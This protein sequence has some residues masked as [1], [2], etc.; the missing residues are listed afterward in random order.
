MGMTAFSSK[1]ILSHSTWY[2]F[3]RSGQ[4][5]PA[6]QPKA[7]HYIA[8]FLRYDVDRA[9]GG[10]FGST[11]GL[12]RSKHA[13]RVFTERRISLAEKRRHVR[14]VKV[15]NPTRVE[16]LLGAHTLIQTFGV[17]ASANGTVIDKIEA[18]P[19]MLAATFMDPPWASSSVVQRLSLSVTAN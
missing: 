4:D 8:D 11:V 12:E 6:S 10:I 14:T 2:K 3:P 13:L 15:D 5:E 19:K 16:E 17:W 18:D 1:W 9:L 7:M